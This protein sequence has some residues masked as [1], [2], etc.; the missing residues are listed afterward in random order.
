[1]LEGPFG[2]DT[3]LSVAVP[4]RAKRAPWGSENDLTGGQMLVSWDLHAMFMNSVALG[5][6]L[7]A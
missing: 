4:D 2:V 6:L 3:P 5:K 1:M 7:A